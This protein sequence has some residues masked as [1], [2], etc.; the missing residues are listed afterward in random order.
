M[1][2]SSTVVTEVDVA[3]SVENTLGRLREQYSAWRKHQAESDSMLYV[4]LENCLEFYYFLRQ[5]EQYESAFKSL[6]H[7]KWNAKTKVSLLI[8]KAVFGEKTKMSNAY[9]R[10]IE[11]AALEQVGRAEQPSM[12]G[13][14]QANGGV[15]GVIRNE[16]PNKSAAA[17][18]RDQQEEVGRNYSR[19]NIACRIQPFEN[20][21]MGSLVVGEWALLCKISSDGR[22]EVVHPSQNEEVVGALYSEYGGLIM[23]TDSYKKRRVIVEAELALQ[24]AHAA[25]VVGEELQRILDRAKSDG[26]V[27]A[28]KTAV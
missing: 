22:V 16:N 13:W 28:T 27:E 8:A 2:N 15:N 24:R 14:L 21:Q 26:E 5:N 20:K 18:L 7:F 1:G 10:A 4:L 25:D 11:K 17:A 19:Y 6:C 12:L 3:V 9:A 23:K